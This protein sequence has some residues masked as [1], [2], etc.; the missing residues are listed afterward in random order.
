M[1]NIVSWYNRNRKKIW[2]SIL[3]IIIISLIAYGLIN[4]T[5][6]NSTSTRPTSERQIDTNSLNSVIL[7]SEK[8][9]ISGQSINID[10]K[11]MSAID[12]FISNCNSGKIAEAYSLISNECKEEMYPEI[13]NFEEFYYKPVLITYIKL[14]ELW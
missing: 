2:T 6:N 14:T 3:A 11:E 4:M 8:S 1:Y 13:N 12:D 7:E 9:V 10:E 5:T